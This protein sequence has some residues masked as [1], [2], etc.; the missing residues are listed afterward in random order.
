MTVGLQ[1]A[2]T[3]SLMHM[4]EQP[5]REK[6]NDVDSDQVWYKPGCAATEDG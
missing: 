5:Q 6:T 2:Q 4:H 1:F 3:Q